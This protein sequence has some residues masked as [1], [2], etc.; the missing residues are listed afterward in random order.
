[1]RASLR[2][3]M[4]FAETAVRNTL[5]RASGIATQFLAGAVSAVVLART[6]GPTQMGV[7]S[8]LLWLVAVLLA[9]A[10]FGIPST[11]TKYIAAS[12]GRGELPIALGL[13]RRLLRVQVLIT[14]A[15]TLLSIATVWRLGGSQSSELTL[16]AL[17]LVVPVALR[18]G[19][20]GILSG[21][22]RYD[23]VAASALYT[24]LAQVLCI[25]VA[26]WLRAGLAG[27]LL[28]TLLAMAL[29]AVATLGL[30][31]NPVR[32]L[33]G[34][35]AAPVPAD[36]RRAIWRF[37]AAA[38]YTT[39][40][41]L[42]LWRRS[43]V[44]FLNHYSMAAQVAFY[45]LSFSLLEKLEVLGA[46]L[47]SVLLPMTSESYGRQGL[48][49]IGPLFTSSVRYLQIAVVPLCFAG[50]ALAGPL[51][52]L[53]F[54]H[55]YVPMIPVLRTLLLMLAPS[56]LGGLAYVF[57]MAID[58]QAFVARLWTGLALLNLV[59]AAL[60]IPAG[61]AFGAAWVKTIVQVGLTAISLGYLA[62]V[63]EA[64]FPWRSVGRIYAAA[65]LTTLPMIAVQWLQPGVILLAASLVLGLVLYAIALRWLGEIGE[66]EINIT[67]AAFLSV[68]YR[69]PRAPVASEI[70][71]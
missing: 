20:L 4:R 39:L 32:Q 71:P 68:L 28:A 66:K 51:V 58:R 60:L 35:V 55:D 2:G 6:L 13:A 33:L 37:A 63:I 30:T 22:Q 11:L 41:S 21:L 46:S 45:S 42:V 57:L 54:G 27:M 26:G 29:G 18:E 69:E 67:R 8:Y 5:L 15:V 1:M 17:L 70:L 59:L 31:R 16:L 23:R 14:A 10:C 3:S 7:Y 25:G 56:C 52:R 48:E 24:A 49:G 40:L 65:A 53:A 34:E 12:M 47:S 62:R 61:G 38:F 9:P 19:L 43:E 50:A 64:A 36:L 44:L